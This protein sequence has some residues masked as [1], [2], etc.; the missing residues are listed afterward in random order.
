MLFGI[1]NRDKWQTLKGVI[2][3][4]PPRNPYY[5]NPVGMKLLFRV[6]SVPEKNTSLL[7]KL[8]GKFSG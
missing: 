6:L 7:V 4:L 1:I 5:P 3:F 8:N 2:L